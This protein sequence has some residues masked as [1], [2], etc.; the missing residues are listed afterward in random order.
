MISWRDFIIILIGAA[1]AFAVLYA[2]A[3]WAIT[4][5]APHP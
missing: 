1:L 2:L 3:F 4:E 5:L